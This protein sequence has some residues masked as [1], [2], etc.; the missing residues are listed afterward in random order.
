MLDLQIEE[1]EKALSS[2][3]IQIIHFIRKQVEGGTNSW[4]HAI[5]SLNHSSY[6]I[7]KDLLPPFRIVRK[8]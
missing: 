1:S 5:N 4:S 7:W 3:H 2:Q 6:W 8:V